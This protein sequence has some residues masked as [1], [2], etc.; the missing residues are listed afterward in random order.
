M[1]LFE[2][3]IENNK[4]PILERRGEGCAFF[5][6]F[7]EVTLF[8]YKVS[9]IL[10]RIVGSGGSTELKLVLTFE[11]HVSDQL[12]SITFYTGGR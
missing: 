2:L 10:L 9:I 3:P 1:L 6:L 5:N 7:S 12:M 4:H 8:E 11:S